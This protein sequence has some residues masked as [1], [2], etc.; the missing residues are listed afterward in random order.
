MKTHTVRIN[1]ETIEKLKNLVNTMIE[2]MP[3]AD[4]IQDWDGK[5]YALVPMPMSAIDNLKKTR[6]EL[7][8]ALAYETRDDK[9]LGD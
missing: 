6:K 4:K 9:K 3:N 8:E 5:K 1:E 2:I 7:E